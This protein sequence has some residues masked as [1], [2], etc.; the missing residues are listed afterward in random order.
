MEERIYN[1]QL[2]GYLG[3]YEIEYFTIPAF[4]PLKKAALYAAGIKNA[5]DISKLQTLK[6]PGIGPKNQQVL[7]DWRRQMAYGYVYIPDPGK[8]AAG[9]QQVAS[10]VATMRA[11]LEKQIRKEY[12][13]LNYMKANITNRAAIMEKHIK[14]LS[15][16]TYQAEADRDAILDFTPNYW[17][18]R[19]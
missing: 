7:L 4:G 1:E 13:S 6:I 12:Q 8:I 2:D 14:D 5:A 16:K 19:Q 17:L 11:Q 15:L 9:T 3:T 18:R 10:E